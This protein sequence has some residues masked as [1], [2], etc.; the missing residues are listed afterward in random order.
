YYV[1]VP[2]SINFLANFSIS[3]DIDNT[4][5]VQNYLSFVATLTLG[6]GIIFELPIVIYILSKLG[7][8]TPQFMRKSR[9][10]AVVIILIIAA[11]ITPSAD[12]V[13]MLT[14]SFPMFILYE[15]SIV[16]ASRVY[17]KRMKAD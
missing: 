1:V 2:L 11:I 14:V 15:L 9:Q 16:V 13:T 12:I 3:S 8:M 4:I 5:T 7:I 17:K 6:C 10:Y